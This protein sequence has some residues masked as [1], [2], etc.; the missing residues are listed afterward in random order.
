VDSSRPRLRLSSPIPL[1]P[2]QLR[3]G[4]WFGATRCQCNWFQMLRMT[5]QRHAGWKS[6]ASAPRKDATEKLFPRAAG[7]RTT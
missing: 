3:R 5:L 1:E 7:P 2:L 6:G 4:F